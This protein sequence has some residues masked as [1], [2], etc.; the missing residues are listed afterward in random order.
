M[1]KNNSELLI[2]RVFDAP[3]EKV[4][5]A[6]TD[7]EEV[8][9][10]WGPRDFTAPHVE[11]DLRVG[12]K[13]LY[14]MR[15]AAGPDV[16]V[17]DYWSGGVFKEIV[18]MEKIVLTSHFTDEKGNQV[19]ATYYDMNADFPMEMEASVIFEAL[20]GKTK[21]TLHYP[22]RGNMPETDRMGMKEGW[23]QSLDKM[24]EALSG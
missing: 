10:W 19:P 7:P 11:I 20:D 23:N 8:K 21:I 13:Y 24:A 1:E 22:D 17:R 12:G 6:W 9:K 4:W 15:G 2:T 18:P 14:C 3:R 16:P 5:K